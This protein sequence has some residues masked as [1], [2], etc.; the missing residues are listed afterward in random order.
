MNNEP[1][2]DHPSLTGID[3]SD[4]PDKVWRCDGCGA[5][6]RW[7]IIDG[8]LGRHVPVEPWEPD[9]TDRPTPRG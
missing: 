2:C 4:G 3:Q 6:T 5:L 9:P 7:E 8:P 1:P